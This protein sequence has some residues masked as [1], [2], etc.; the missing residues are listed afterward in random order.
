MECNSGARC[1]SGSGSRR[2]LY[3]PLVQFFGR[4]DRLDDLNALAGNTAS[5]AMARSSADSRQSARAIS[6]VIGSWAP[7]ID[8]YLDALSF[9]PR[10]HLELLRWRGARIVFAPT[11]A[12]ALTTE[13]A[14][15]QRG[16]PLDLC[17]TWEVRV[18]YGPDGG[19]AAVYDP[20]TDW[21]IFPT[22][23]CNKDLRRAALHEL[24]HALTVRRATIREGMLDQL[25]VRLHRHV[26]STGYEVPGDPAQ[27][28]RQ[29]VL[30][31]LAEGYIYVIEGR[32]EELPDALSSELVFM[33]QTVDEGDRVRFE[34]EKTDTG[35]RTASRAAKREI[36][37]GDDP[38]YGH[39]FAPLRVGR[40]AEPRSLAADELAARRSRRHDAA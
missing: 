19:V 40:H 7:I 25:P 28:L 12:D 29:R 8:R 33:L 15:Q 27:T 4:V 36:V 2:R 20:D 9:A 30:E 39:L 37:D 6:D 11:I 22:A 24:G 32:G 1:E 10:A 14:A 18:E 17:E 31:A 26:F 34:F 5:Y 35:E 38:E 23:Y 21:L 16:R 3:A 13:L